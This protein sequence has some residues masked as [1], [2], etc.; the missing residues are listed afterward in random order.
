MNKGP[1]YYLKAASQ[2]IG[3]RIW[4]RYKR[5]NVTLFRY[6]TALGDA[7]FLTTLAREVKKRNPRAHIHVITGLPM[8]FDRNPDVDKV[9]REPNEKTPGLGRFLV[10][11]EHKFPWQGKHLLEHCKEVVDIRDEIEHRTY[12]F[13]SAEDHQWAEDLVREI[14]EAPILINRVAGPRTDKKNWPNEYWEK[15]VPEL[16]KIAP[17]VEIGTQYP[18]PLPKDPR[19][20]DLVKKTSLHQTAALM[21]RSRL[22]ICPVTGTLHLA[23][24]YD[25]PTLCI[26]GG[27]EPAYATAYPNTHYIENRPPC[28][29]CYEQGPCGFEFR[30][31]TGITVKEVIIS[32]ED[33]LTK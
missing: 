26:L 4:P 30:C 10:R 12:I 18:S 32:I 19:F 1:V 21:K 8:I 14:G 15:L 31:L 24:A 7:L 17:V 23:A 16:L 28:A 29:D 33:I 22:L 6:T 5:K 11:Y 25:L 3:R 2:K 20:T 27:S 13:P 9:S